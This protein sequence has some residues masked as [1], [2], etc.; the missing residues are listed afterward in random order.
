MGGGCRP[1]VWHFFHHSLGGK[2]GSTWAKDLEGVK[3]QMCESE[4]GQVWER[5]IEIE[6]EME[7]ENKRKWRSRGEIVYVLGCKR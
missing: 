1:A 5:E 3:E 6:G 4:S 7:M 2:C